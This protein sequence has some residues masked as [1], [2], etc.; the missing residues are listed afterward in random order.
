M[1]ELEE[2]G[3]LAGQGG[4][5]FQRL[6]LALLDLH[7]STP[8]VAL[9]ATSSDAA[10]AE[11]AALQRLVAPARGG[12]FGAIIDDPWLQPLKAALSRE[13][14]DDALA[15]GGLD[16]LQGHLAESLAAWAEAAPAD[17]QEARAAAKLI[18]G[19]AALQLYLRVN[20][21]GPACPATGTEILPFDPA[22]SADVAQESHK[23][24]MEALLVDGEPAYELTI[25]P[26][27][28]WLAT[29]LL[30]VRP[31]GETSSLAATA[32]LHSTL[33]VW[34]GRCAFAWQRSL[35][36]A[37]DN[38]LGQ[39]PF[40]FAVGVY[41]M[42]GM[43]EVP[44]PLA[45]PGLLDG[46]ALEAVRQA[47]YAVAKATRQVRGVSA[48]APIVLG[49]AMVEDTPEEGVAECADGA[50]EPAPA[51]PAFPASLASGGLRAALLC[52]LSIR[53]SWYNRFKPFDH[54]DQAACDA[55]GISYE[56]TGAPGIKRK[57]QTVEFAQMVVKVKRTGEKVFHPEDKAVPGESHTP[58][59]LTL[60]EVDDL[61]D[62]LEATKF[63]DNMG[64]EDKLSIERPLSAPEQLILIARCHKLWASCN[65]SDMHLLETVNALATRVLRQE[66]SD[67]DGHKGTANWLTFSS[68]LWWRCRCEHHRNK[69]VERAAFQLESLVDQFPKEEPVA[70][71]RLLLVHAAGYPA[72]F[73]LMHEMGSRMMK[74][75]LVSTAHEQ[76]K[77]LKMWTEAVDCL[78][79]RGR[80]VEATDMIK[81]LLETEPTP[82]LWCCL[83]DLEK[84]SATKVELYEKAW[85]MSNKRLARV[86]RALGH[87][88]FDKSKLP[89]AVECFATA[90][91]IN[92]MH[93]N[94]WFKMGCI[95]MQLQRFKDAVVTF[96]RCIGINDDLAEGW[97]NLA[98][99]HQQLGNLR[100]ARSC[101][102]EACKRARG[103]WKMWD[104]S[105]AISMQLKDIQGAIYAMRRLAELN[106]APRI[107][108]R[109]MGMVTHAVLTDMDG[110]FDSLTGMAY[111][112]NLT[113][114]FLDLATRHTQVPYFWKYHSH[115]QLVNGNAA[116]SL[117]C[118]LKEYR[119]REASLWDEID[120][121]AFT[122]G[123][124][125]LYECFEAIE[126][127]LA[128]P[129]LAGE[130]VRL[131][132][133]VAMAVRN[134]ATKLH[135]K[136]Q[137]GVPHSTWQKQM[138]ELSALATRMESSAAS[139]GNCGGA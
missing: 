42:V 94:I 106:Q 14:V 32:S 75:G 67:D 26:G 98:A 41:G 115:V 101:I 30:G 13:S 132:G 104:S 44:G 37:S 28:L 85:S 65:H 92:P 91:E 48:G 39:S 77:K 66:G 87:H 97:A 74:M 89:E 33:D 122:H 113:S 5:Y 27:F 31:H 51:S 20:F 137:R 59:N 80:N 139:L 78:M 107:R 79:I 35:Q 116:E 131:T 8:D 124:E 62:I 38:G 126:K 111:L 56:V 53:L 54:I 117:E 90:L 134:A 40:L 109:T 16:R 7:G 4:D 2:A 82:R 25:A 63:S 81:A 58:G 3:D 84:D 138:D 130:A 10:A 93:S 36:E 72:V 129:E 43:P 133:S 22:V 110:L 70:P 21:T 23:C 100:E 71:H 1:V 112:K 103:S 119:A 47:T 24:I 68:G 19:V 135:N 108:E 86:Q 114:F 12:D 6:E 18:L 118:R 73:Q 46:E 9:P 120:L 95:Q 69:T 136:M 88:Y 50:A 17:C 127:K 121:E 61:T 34:R 29:M 125:D 105:L 52:E 55:L 60:L 96:S 57:Y 64:E 15:L 128:E 83:A 123:V 102:S 99:A 49:V 45:G 76:F 11:Y